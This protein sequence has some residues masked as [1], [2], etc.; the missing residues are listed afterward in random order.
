MTKKAIPYGMEWTSQKSILK[1][2]KIGILKSI[3]P[4]PNFSRKVI[5]DNANSLSYYIITIIYPSRITT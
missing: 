4:L 5:L 2:R 1:I 3:E